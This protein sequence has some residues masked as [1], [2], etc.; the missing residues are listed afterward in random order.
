VLFRS[1]TIDLA[2]YT[3]YLYLHL[4]PLMLDFMLSLSAGVQVNFFTDS[5][6]NLASKTAKLQLNFNDSG[7]GTLTRIYPEMKV[8]FRDGMGCRSKTFIFRNMRGG[9]DHFT[10]TGTQDRSVE[11]SGSEFDRH[12][13]FNRAEATFD[14]LRGQHNN[15]NLWNSKKEILSIF[16]QKVK[17]KYET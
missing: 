17:K 2:G 7:T 1:Q 16:S 15:T 4:H 5:S 8:S 9:F 11:L 13:D 3:G 10:A 6:G 14:L 12:T